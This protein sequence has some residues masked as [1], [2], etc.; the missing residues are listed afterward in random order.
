ML[1]K[2]R[3]MAGLII[4]L[5]ACPLSAANY[6][7]AHLLDS[8]D[9][10]DGCSLREAIFAHNSSNLKGAN[11]CGAFDPGADT[12]EFSFGVTGTLRLDPA[13]GELVL[14]EPEL[15]IQGPGASQLSISGGKVMSV[16]VLDLVRPPVFTLRG[17]TIRNGLGSAPSTGGNA[18]GG[19]IR[20]DL[21]HWPVP[22]NPTTI[23]V[24]DCDFF[25]NSAPMGV[26]SRGAAIMS[27]GTLTLRRTKFR[28]NQSDTGALW[29]FGEA[30]IEDCEF[31][32]NFG[33]YLASGAVLFW[34]GPWT[35]RRTL[36][37]KNTV[38]LNGS[39]LNFYANDGKGLVENSTF[40]SN[41]SST[42]EAIYSSQAALIV[43]NSTFV[44]TA[45]VGGVG[46]GGAVVSIGASSLD[47]RSSLFAR[48]DRSD[49]VAVSVTSA[50]NLFDTSAANLPA[51][52]VCA[53][54]TL[55]GA[56]LCGVTSPG[57]GPLSNNGGPT[58]TF[59]ILLGPA[60]NAGWAQSGLLTD[61]RGPG[62]ARTVG[63]GTDI[64]AFEAQ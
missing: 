24:E 22:A 62:F 52:T 59:P 56:N 29:H 17:A 3:F 4:A 36:F 51:G 39:A 50:Y 30:L 47:L 23:L 48:N 54:T 11:E 42:G 35:V 28:F 57:I 16:F 61:Q 40:S 63:L 15:T 10:G 58:Q 9:T 45:Q 60:F 19:G 26:T 38:H 1:K 13:L 49:A 20:M 27:Y 7:V 25:A 44:D 55:G 31:S 2:R 41:T 33:E 43:R 21:G 34:P 5:C 18:Q 32:D 12:I 37:L 6:K 64:G 14:T 46:G 53:T 8:W